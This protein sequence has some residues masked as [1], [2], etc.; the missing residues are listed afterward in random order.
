[1]R[2]VF[3]SVLTVI[4]LAAVGGCMPRKPANPEAE[5]AALTAARDW[6]AL[7]DEGAYGTAWEEAGGY[8]RNALTKDQWIRSMRAAREPMGEVVS[9]EKKKSRYATTMPGAPDGQYVMIRFETAFAEKEAAVETI[10][11]MLDE[12]SGIWRVTGY[13]IK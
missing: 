9:R 1:M 3:L 7:L 10:T 5:Q 12:E 6:V 13:Y 2:R 4:G 11:P 8:F